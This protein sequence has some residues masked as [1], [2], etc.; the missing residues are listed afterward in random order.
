MAMQQKD[1]LGQPKKL[2]DNRSKGGAPR[3]AAKPA[4]EPGMAG[5]YDPAGSVIPEEVR[6]F[7]RDSQGQMPRRSR[8]PNI[9]GGGHATP[10]QT[11][12]P[13]LG[14][15]M[16]PPPAVA[17]LLQQSPMYAPPPAPAPMQQA[18][19]TLGTLPPAAEGYAQIEAA[20]SGGAPAGPNLSVDENGN[21]VDEYG[22]VYDQ[23]NNIVPPPGEALAVP[24]PAAQD[25]F[26]TP[27]MVS[28]LYSGTMGVMGETSPAALDQA[29]AEMMR[30]GMAGIESNLAQQQFNAM[31]RSAASNFGISGGADTGQLMLQS[32]AMGE[33]GE[34]YSSI[35]G[36]KAQAEQ[37]ATA[38]RLQAYLQLH[39]QYLSAGEQE[40]IQGALLEQQQHEID[41]E[42]AVT[43]PANLTT[44]MKENYD[45]LSPTAQARYQDRL[46]ELFTESGDWTWAYQQV[47][48]ELAADWG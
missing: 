26:V 14:M 46:H 33:Q 36:Q 34:M 11:A 47:A 37:A 20:A 9:P 3:M 1:S 32:A 7:M 41:T 42:L 17:G 31:D 48:Q 43:T 13:N 22:R 40:S 45:F 12:V 5:F 29:Y 10:R 25:D 27:E 21:V 8:V 18:P 39:G 30:G 23:D 35:M 4:R 16:A 6:P 28:D 19:G 38:Q 2:R 15:Q 44:H 24:V